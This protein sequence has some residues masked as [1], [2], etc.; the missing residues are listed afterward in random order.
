MKKIFASEELAR[1]A[2]YHASEEARKLGRE[3][4][5]DAVVDIYDG[6]VYKNENDNDPRNLFLGLAFDGFLPF[7]E[8]KKYSMWPIVLTPYNFRPSLR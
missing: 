6:S 7:K 2:V 1:E 4:D 8:D 5:L 3:C